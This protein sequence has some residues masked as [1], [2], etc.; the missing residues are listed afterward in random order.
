MITIALVALC[1]A[2]LG[3]RM[4]AERHAAEATALA[5]SNAEL[6]FRLTKVY[7]V[8]NDRPAAFATLRAAVAAGYAAT[9]AKEDEEL[10]A[11]H[12]AEFDAAL[13]AGLAGRDAAV[14]RKQ[15]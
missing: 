3:Q 2:N 1:E 11:L 12:G 6:R 13:A 15:Q 7:A 8:L 14:W 9:A 4:E 10:V 5:S